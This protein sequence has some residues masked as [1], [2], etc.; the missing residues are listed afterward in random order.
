LNGFLGS[1]ASFMLDVVFLAMFII[2]PLLGWSIWLVR[3]GKHEMH[4]RLQLTIAVTLLVAIIAFEVDLRFFTDWRAKA[5]LSPYFE[6]NGQWNAVWV[7]LVIHLTFAVPTTILWVW[8]VAQA[9]R[10][11]PKPPKPGAH[12]RQH[13]L[14][15]RLAGAGMLF[16]AVTGWC[17]YWLAFVAT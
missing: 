12:S 11:F 9:L 8:V 15:G 6:N 7:S 5:A 1:R 14:F 3:R 2:V 4:K 16:T 17:F 13:R 10:A